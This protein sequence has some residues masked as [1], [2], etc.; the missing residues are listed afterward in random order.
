[1]SVQVQS[2]DESFGIQLRIEESTRVIKLGSYVL[3]FIS[4]QRKDAR[5]F[6]GHQRTLMDPRSPERGLCQPM[7]L[8]QH[9]RDTARAYVL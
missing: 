7:M 4:L 9:L 5:V 2:V 8:L 1:M 6:R 3:E